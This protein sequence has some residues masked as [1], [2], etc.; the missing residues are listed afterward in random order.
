MEERPEM[1][2]QALATPVTRVAGG[3]REVRLP[4]PIAVMV[5]ICGAFLGFVSYKAAYFF[6]LGVCLIG[7]GAWLARLFF[8]WKED[9]DDH[10]AFKASR[11]Y[12]LRT[13][14][15]HRKVYKE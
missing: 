6:A 5:A 11:D 3:L 12:G 2:S 4:L 1:D 15:K 14:V 13:L 9:R 8:E 10:A 7:V